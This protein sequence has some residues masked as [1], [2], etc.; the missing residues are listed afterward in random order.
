MK[1]S[2]VLKALTALAQLNRLR[3]FRKLVIAG[4]AGSTPT[5]IA[6]Q[7][8]LQPATLSFHLKE[9]MNAGLVTQERSGRNLIYRADFART[10]D[11]LAY[12]SENC[13]QGERPAGAGGGCQTPTLKET[14]A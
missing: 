5:T 8:K 7:M 9:L 11:L 4:H 10:N 1:E 3:V 12:L 13:C 14:K 6:K 2:A